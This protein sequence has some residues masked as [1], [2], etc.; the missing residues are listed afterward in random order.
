MFDPS[1]VPAA[2]Q[3]SEFDDLAIKKT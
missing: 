3:P 2:L 1:R